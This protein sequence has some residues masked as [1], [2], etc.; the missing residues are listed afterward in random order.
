MNTRTLIKAGLSLLI[1][2]GAA[3]A[4]AGYVNTVGFFDPTGAP[5]QPFSVIQGAAAWIPP[6]NTMLI[7]P[8][9][10]QETVTLD[11]VMELQTTGQ[12]VII[13][14]MNPQSTTFRVVCYN[15]HLFGNDSIPGLPRW[16]DAARA[17]FIGDVI[18]DDG[19]DVV[20]L[21]EVWDPAF[22]G[23]IASQSGYPSGFYGG[24]VA[25]GRVLNSGLALYSAHQIQSPA[26]VVYSDVDM[27]SFDSMAS[28]G[29]VS[30]TI[31]KGPFTIGFFSTHTQSG[32]SSTNALFRG[33][34]LQ[35]LGA[36]VAAY[37]Q[38]FPGRPVVVVGDF[39][40]I[41]ESPEYA[42]AMRGSMWGTARTKDGLRNLPITNDPWCTSCQSNQLNMH[43]NSSAGN[44]R[45][46]Y[47][48]YAGS[49]D[50]TV[51]IIPTRYERKEFQVPPQFPPLSGSGL[52]TRDLSD[53]YGVVMDFELRR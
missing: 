38:V 33:A 8:G 3:Q 9:V 32:E 39:N 23:T 17:F 6:G 44:I 14:Q 30:C 18:N 22:F 45:L 13:G 35:Q 53:H 29:F 12:P 46:D 27:A 11:R 7:G 1:A 34:Q 37:R 16:L 26:Q 40:V 31:T 43:F 19:A 42:G 50:G 4:Q 41:S 48:L 47:V 28:K 24:S 36:A 51:E 2:A 49:L 10:Y 21:Q 52:T 5:T 25:P 20:G 15:T